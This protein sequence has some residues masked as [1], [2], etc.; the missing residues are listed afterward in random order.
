MPDS[1]RSRASCI[2]HCRIW[3]D[4][5]P[6][7]VVR[8]DFDAP[9]RLKD[10]NEPFRAVRAQVLQQIWGCYIGYTWGF[11]ILQLVDFPLYLF[12]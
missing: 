1:S 7:P 10:G 3:Q 2:F 4:D 8:N 5:A 9:H 11:S 6:A 12:L